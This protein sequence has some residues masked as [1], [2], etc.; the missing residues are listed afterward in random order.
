M[1]RPSDPLLRLIRD[2]SRKKGM[3]TAALAKE[4]GIDRARLKHVLGGS[5]SMTVDELL[6]VANALQIDAR[7]LGM[8][9]SEFEDGAAD[10]AKEH[11]DRKDS[12]APAIVPERDAPWLVDPYG[13]HAEQAL[14][15]GF[16]LGCNLWLRLDSSTLEKSGV[17]LDV[18]QSQGETLRIQLDAAYHRHNKPVFHPDHL[19]IVLSFGTTLYTVKLPW[20]SFRQVALVPLPPQPQPTIDP[21]AK[22]QSRAHLRLVE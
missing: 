1:S 5:E 16:G 6:L 19:Q 10:G 18:I 4:S 17:P 15:L 20:E 14:R 22:G 7:T 13:N 8:Q 2:L 12:S 11:G 21:T 9:G 3:N